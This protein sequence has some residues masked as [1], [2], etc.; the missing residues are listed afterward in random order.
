MT[1]RKLFGSRE[2]LADMKLCVLPGVLV[3][4]LL[5]SYCTLGS[6]VVI[7]K[8]QTPSDDCYF[9]TLPSSTISVGPTCPNVV[10]DHV[11]RCPIRVCYTGPGTCTTWRLINGN[12]YAPL[13]FD[14]SSGTSALFTPTDLESVIVQCIAVADGVSNIYKVHFETGAVVFSMIVNVYSS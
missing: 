3:L 9:D 10:V 11:S 4:V 7:E 6:R 1:D 13:Y 14:A 5:G 8:R 2:T 12:T